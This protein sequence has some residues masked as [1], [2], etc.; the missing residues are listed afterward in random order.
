MTDQLG[1]YFIDIFN[2]LL[3]VFDRNIAVCEHCSGE[4]RRDRQ[5]WKLIFVFAIWMCYSPYCLP[6]VYLDQCT[7]VL[8]PQSPQEGEWCMMTSSNGNIFPRYRPFVRGIHRSPVNS[9]HKGQWRGALMFSLIC[10]WING[11]VNNC[12][13]GDLGRYRAHYDVTVMGC[14]TDALLWHNKYMFKPRD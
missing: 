13:A 4:W 12:E 8:L 3:C 1:Q 6:D 11:W 9:P 14:I 10:A 5:K 2:K 7:C